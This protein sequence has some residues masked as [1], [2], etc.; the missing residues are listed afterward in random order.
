M[1]GIQERHSPE[2]RCENRQSGEW[3]ESMQKCVAI[4]LQ[5]Q[6]GAGLQMD[7]NPLAYRHPTLLH[8]LKLKKLIKSGGCLGRHQTPLKPA[9]KVRK[10]PEI[11]DRRLPAFNTFPRFK[12]K[13]HIPLIVDCCT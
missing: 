5:Q 7:E 8:A 3:R 12:G 10:I 4:T 11:V 13:G 9:P 6:V 1:S 2:R